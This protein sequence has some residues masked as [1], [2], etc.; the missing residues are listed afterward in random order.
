MDLKN[1]FSDKGKDTLSEPG[2][3]QPEV[4]QEVN[5]EPKKIP[6]PT[7]LISPSAQGYVNQMVSAAVAESVKAIFAQ[8]APVLQASALTPE[9]LDLLR[10]VKK[11]PE[12]EAKELREQRESRKSREE[13]AQLRRDR[14]AMQDRCPHLDD[15]GKDAIGIIRNY[16]D[17]Q[18]RGLCMKCNRLIEPRRW[19]IGAPYP[20]DHPD[21]TKRGKEHAY[22]ADADPGY[23]PV[24]IIAARS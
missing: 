20:L 10:T 11:T 18:P 19:V 17:R 9:K 15:A 8:L 21:P 23:E 16:P 3:A 1:I 22:I 24:A 14:I 2:V 6:T 12:Q 5:Q 13:E 4:K 7:E